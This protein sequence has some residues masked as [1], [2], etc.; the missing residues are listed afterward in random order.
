MDLHNP[1][2]KQY[3]VDF[4]AEKKPNFVNRLLNFAQYFHELS[5]NIVVF[6]YRVFFAPGVNSEF[7]FVFCY[8]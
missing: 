5:N 3:N 6:V 2:K 8:K 7:S 4:P 1:M